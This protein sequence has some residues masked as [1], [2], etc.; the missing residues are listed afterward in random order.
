MKFFKYKLYASISHGLVV[1][2]FFGGMLANFFLFS[3]VLDEEEN[4][5]FCADVGDYTW[6][7]T[8]GLNNCEAF[9]KDMQDLSDENLQALRKHLIDSVA[10]LFDSQR[11]YDG[12]LYIINPDGSLARGP[13]GEECNAIE[14]VESRHGKYA[15]NFLHA[16]LTERSSGPK[17]YFNAK[18]LKVLYSEY[19]DGLDLMYFMTVDYRK[20]ASDRIITL[21]RLLLIMIF[22]GLLIIYISFLNLRKTFKRFVKDDSMQKDIE[23]ASAIQSAML[24]VGSRHF[25]KIDMD[26]CLHPAYKVGGDLYYYLSRNGRLY[27]CIGDVSGKGIPAAL[28]MSRAMSL[29]RNYCLFTDSP[30][31]I[32]GLM[33]ED[34]C[35]NN[36]QDVFI[37][38]FVGVLRLSDGM[39]YYC[40]AG[41]EYPMYWN[42]NPDSQADFLHTSR[43]LP[44]GFD[45]SSAYKEDKL[46]LGN[47][48]MFFL[49]TDGVTEARGNK[50]SLYGKDKLASLIN[51]IKHLSAGEINASVL[52]AVHSFEGKD[53]QSD[54]ITLLTL[55]NIHHPKTLILTNNVN[56]LKL[57]PGFLAD[58]FNQCEIS[59]KQKLMIRTSLDEALTNCVLYA[60][61]DGA[62]GE[63]TLEASA[64]DQV[65]T[66]KIEDSG[67]AFD[68]LSYE[69]EEQDELKV[70]GLG[71][72]LIKKNFDKLSYQRTD[73]KNILTLKVLF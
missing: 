43:N 57:L 13:Y 39:L 26:A 22:G 48:S 7:I 67:I 49:Y 53:R 70:G 32:A 29:F 56:D 62:V 63:I 8:S 34:L 73:I 71:I 24:P 10:T 27:F 69:A 66:F 72:P 55:R 46:L 18:E 3:P 5:R 40:N 6:E 59:D 42:G 68:P 35:I 19:E 37:T 52:G 64:N 47:D 60:Y 41:H 50:T 20:C 4:R 9:S 2:V 23:T 36:S 45:V 51:G 28:F 21:I 54:D 25:M 38:C 12:L 44:L 17:S 16:G 58:V 61:P 30:A 31:K 15:S 11:P 1:I 33:N 14:L 65:L